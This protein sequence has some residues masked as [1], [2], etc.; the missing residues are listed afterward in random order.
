MK[1]LVVEDELAQAETL[2]LLLEQAGHTVYLAP[3]VDAAKVV[4]ETHPPEGVVLD[5]MLPGGSGEGL[6]TWLREQ[7]ALAA[8]PVV[9]VTGMPVGEA[10]TLPPDANL[11]TLQ[12]PFTV[13]ELLGAFAFLLSRGMG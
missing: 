1:L 2:Q 9:L 5:L 11:M 13:E 12:K 6:L 10:D 8:L 7:P 4:A 3:T